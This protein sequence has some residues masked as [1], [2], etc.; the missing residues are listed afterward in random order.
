VAAAPA[1]ESFFRDLEV[2]ME[3][4]GPAALHWWLRERVDCE[5][6]NPAAPALVTPAK[7]R[8][9]INSK[10]DLAKWVWQLRADPRSVLRLGAVELE[11]DLYSAQDLL[12]LYDPERRRG[13]TAQG[14]GRELQRAS[15]RVLGGGFTQTSDGPKQLFAVRNAEKWASASA[16]AVAAHYAG[17]TVKEE[18]KRKKF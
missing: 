15:V 7:E 8:M 18:P 12:E 11:R 3:T 6:F 1:D 16:K 13:V 2:W 14:I 17:S 10:S 5:G 4:T 9:I